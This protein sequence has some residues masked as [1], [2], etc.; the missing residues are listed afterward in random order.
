M[1]KEYQNQFLL[2]SF[3]WLLMTLL[4][5]SSCGTDSN[6]AN[7]VTFSDGIHEEILE[8]LDEEM[9]DTIEHELEMPIHRGSN[10]PFIESF[11]GD[12][13]GSDGITFVM[14]PNIRKSTNVPTDPPEGGQQF[15]DNYVRLSNQNPDLYTIDF[16]RRHIDREP[17]YGS[18]AYIIGEDNRFSVFAIQMSDRP[19]GVAI[20][21]NIFS[22][23]VS[24]HGI[25]EAHY[26]FFLVDNG[27]AS[28]FIPNGTGRTFEDG[29]GI[30]EISVWPE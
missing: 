5:F 20:S 21:M 14:A 11:Y 1:M 27:G 6:D 18:G 17:F 22:G 30:A 2:T 24:A 28:G 3:T 13:A 26:A 29:E 25:E 4:L 16:D 12:H 19:G 10:P 9:L 7:D 23:I 8:T 15:L